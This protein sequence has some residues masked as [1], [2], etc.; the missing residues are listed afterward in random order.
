MVRPLRRGEGRSPFLYGARFSP[1]AARRDRIAL[2]GVLLVTLFLIVLGRM[3]LFAGAP[4]W[5]LWAPVVAL[6]RATALSPTAPPA[7]ERPRLSPA[8]AQPDTSWGR[9]APALGVLPVSGRLLVGAGTDDGVREGDIVLAPALENASDLRYVG[10]IVTADEGRSRVLLPRDPASLLPV[11]IEG[12]GA[13]GLLGRGTGRGFRVHYLTAD[14]ARRLVAGAR[15]WLAPA[16]LPESLAGAHFEVGRTD[17]EPEREGTFYSVD[18]ELS[19]DP[20][21]IEWVVIPPQAG[22]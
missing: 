13:D 14:A 9:P 4:V 2:G 15:V 1:T 18:V 7:I 17:S 19:V 8:P 11:A 6:S 3:G 5:P 20:A 16:V 12:I 10:R 21:R 22:R